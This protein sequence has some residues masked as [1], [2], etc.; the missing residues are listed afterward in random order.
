MNYKG[1]LKANFIAVSDKSNSVKSNSTFRFKITELR[2]INVISAQ[3][4]DDNSYNDLFN[5]SIQFTNPMGQI[6]TIKDTITITQDN[7]TLVIN[8]INPLRLYDIKTE[9]THKV[10]KG[11]YFEAFKGFRLFDSACALLYNIAIF[12][13]S[14]FAPSHIHSK[15]DEIYF[16]KITANF[17]GQD[18]ATNE[19]VP[20]EQLL[21]EQINN[22]EELDD[23]ANDLDNQ[24]DSLDAS[25]ESKT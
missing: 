15:T 3:I 19:N 17:I 8:G 23:I 25:I 13:P 5:S 6:Q 12:V 18:K 16:G 24:V 21:S 11:Y 2:K 1:Q 9:D 22:T 10:S 14:L 20:E 4:I 7:Q